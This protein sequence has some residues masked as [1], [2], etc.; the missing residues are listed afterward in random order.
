MD[1]SSLPRRGT[2]AAAPTQGT[3]PLAAPVSEMAIS[4]AAPP[5]SAQLSSHLC[6]S[7]TLPSW[8][9]RSI[10]PVEEGNESS[11]AERSLSANV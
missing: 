6:V 5:A 11:A 8:M 7:T 1:T 10:Q 3:K 4:F 2:R 9:S